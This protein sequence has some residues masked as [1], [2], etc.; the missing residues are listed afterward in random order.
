MIAPRESDLDVRALETLARVVV[1][2]ADA[3]CR[4]T[5]DRA[6]NESRRLVLEAR[7]VLAVSGERTV[8]FSLPAGSLA[9]LSL[10]YD[11][12]EPKRRHNVVSEM[13]AV[14]GQDGWRYTYGP[15]SGPAEGDLVRDEVNNFYHKQK[16]ESPTWTCSL[17]RIPVSHEAVSELLD[18]PRGV[19]SVG[20]Y[21][22]TL[23]ELDVF[24]AASSDVHK[25]LAV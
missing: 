7:P 5:E 3:A 21:S 25:A 13:S 20:V 19:E 1:E 14:Q 8:T 6:L 9:T 11:A 2:D 23:K 12:V 18:L 17:G 10:Q 15:A 16:V 4:R 22:R 24:A